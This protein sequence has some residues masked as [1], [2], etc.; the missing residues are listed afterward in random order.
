MST[1]TLAIQAATALTLLNPAQAGGEIWLD[2]SVVRDEGRWRHGQV[3]VLDWVRY[4]AGH[5]SWFQPDGLH[6][7]FSGAAAFARL[8]GAGEFRCRR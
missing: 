5:G 4:S 8:L 3:H 1:Q 7:T 2:A 6:L